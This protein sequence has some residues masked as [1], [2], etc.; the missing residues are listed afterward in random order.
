MSIETRLGF[1]WE[2]MVEDLPEGKEKGLTILQTIAFYEQKCIWEPLYEIGYG[3]DSC[4]Q[5]HD[6]DVNMRALELE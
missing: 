2:V 3:I 5:V 4:I 1:L 6:V